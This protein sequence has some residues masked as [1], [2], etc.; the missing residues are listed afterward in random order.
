M[1]VLSRRLNEKIV[2]PSISTRIQVVAIKAGIVRLGIDAPPSV[3]IYREELL[4]RDDFVESLAVGNHQP[5]AE[6][7]LHRLTRQVRESVA[8]ALAALDRLGHQLETGHVA[9]TAGTIDRIET[10]LR[11]LERLVGPGAN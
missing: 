3:P 5:D 7:R 11:R 10:E 1:L 6:A 2:L 8:F 4:D 9:P